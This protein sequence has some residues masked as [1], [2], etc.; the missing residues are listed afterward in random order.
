LNTTLDVDQRE[1]MSGAESVATGVHSIADS[2]EPLAQTPKH[3]SEPGGAAAEPQSISGAIRPPF[4]SS[5]SAADNMLRVPSEVSVMTGAQLA[6]L[7]CKTLH[8]LEIP[9]DALVARC[10]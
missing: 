3:Q 5:A 1:A 4:V 7:A 2:I 10:A 6:S 8:S 9:T